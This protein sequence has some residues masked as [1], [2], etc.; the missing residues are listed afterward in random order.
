MCSNRGSRMKIERNIK[1]LDSGPEIAILGHIV[2]QNEVRI[3]GLCKT[4]DESTT[5]VCV[6]IESFYQERLFQR[7]KVG[8]PPIR[9]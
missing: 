4:V 6:D 1:L 7:P 3:A 8:I 2:E 5:K 9:K